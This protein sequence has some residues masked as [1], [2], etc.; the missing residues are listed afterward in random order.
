MF[1]TFEGPDGSGK[2]TQINK[3]VK[4]LEESN[5]P[6]VFTREP[7][8]QHSKA[9]GKIR[10]IL[11]DKENQIPPLTEAMLFAADRKMHL[12][13]VILPALKENKLVIC[14]RY[15]DSSLAYQG[16]GRQ[17]GI[18]KIKLL[19]EIAI[20]SKYPDYTFFFDLKPEDSKLRINNREESRDRFELSGESFN[21]RVYQGYL[22]VIKLFP[23][24][25]VIIDASKPID[26]VFEQLKKEFSEK[27]I[28]KMQ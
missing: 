16:A 24:R 5:V 4:F 21:E 14:D 27:V 25:F 23:E 28:S 12:D 22:D 15:V 7:G 8:T 3:L 9:S 2:T 18:E 19:N 11:V 1:I 10:E 26:D 20:E 17:L 6:F 13:Q